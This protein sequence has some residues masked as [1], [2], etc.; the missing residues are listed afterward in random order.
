MI[1][2][3]H[4]LKVGTSLRLQKWIRLKILQKYLIVY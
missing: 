1:N 4:M 3:I 2:L